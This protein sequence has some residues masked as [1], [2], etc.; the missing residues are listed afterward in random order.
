M[1]DMDRKSWKILVVDDEVE[2]HKVTEM[3]LS[4]I[5][6]M[7]RPL[8]LIFAE[9][10]REAVEIINQSPDVSAILLDVVMENDHAGLDFVK[11]VRE[12]LDND[13]VKIILR[14]GQPGSAPEKETIEEYDINDYLAKSE[15]TPQRLFTSIKTALRDYRH[16]EIIQ[17][18]NRKIIKDQEVLTLI[19][20]LVFILVV[21]QVFILFFINK[22]L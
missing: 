7:E 22:L 6:F 13:S 8:E 21:F 11:Y 1:N 3:V 5:T 14:T 10:K 9:S 12:E 16:F 2:I 20:V 18:Q 17:K 4:D 19:G 15:I